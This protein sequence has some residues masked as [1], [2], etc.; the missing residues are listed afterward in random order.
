[1]RWYLLTFFALVFVGCSCSD[2]SKFKVSNSDYI[3]V[4]CSDFLYRKGLVERKK[5]NDL[6]KS[7]IN[8]LC[9]IIGNISQDQ[10]I[11]NF[12][13]YAPNLV[14]KFRGLDLNFIS[15]KTA[16]INVS[17]PNGKYNQYLFSPD[18]R[19]MDF[20]FRIKRDYFAKTK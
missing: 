6:S 7:D 16:I 12:T 2:E 13:S 17:L 3:G 15:E 19:G 20:F 10:V 8:F 18:K 14:F 9:S 1:M 11:E 5:L 4:S